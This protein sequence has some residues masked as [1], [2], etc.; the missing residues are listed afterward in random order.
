VA[1]EILQQV[2]LFLFRERADVLWR[3]SLSHGPA[4]LCFI[5]GYVP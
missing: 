4:V 1:Q 2:A 5:A 3:L